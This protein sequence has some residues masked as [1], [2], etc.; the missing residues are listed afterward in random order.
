MKNELAEALAERAELL[1]VG[2]IR[3]A[4]CIHTT[5]IYITQAFVLTLTAHPDCYI[6][7]FFG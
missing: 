6:A 3:H 7:T 4:I 2:G 1:E 5:I